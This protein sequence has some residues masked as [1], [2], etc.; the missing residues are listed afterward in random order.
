[1]N[2]DLGGIL[3]LIILYGMVL[4][5]KVP[6]IY[7]SYGKRELLIYLV[8]MFLSLIIPV[9]LLM[10]ISVPSPISL[11]NKVLMDPMR[12][13]LEEPGHAEPEGFV[14]PRAGFSFLVS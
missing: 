7:I 13:L 10:N 8:A 4:T 1:M 2:V 11:I 12:N 6:G 5:L 3:A 9:I 14:F